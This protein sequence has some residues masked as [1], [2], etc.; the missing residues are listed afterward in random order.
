MTKGGK[1]LKIMGCHQVQR[2]RFRHYG[3][4][5]E[6]WHRCCPWWQLYLVTDLN[7]G[8]QNERK[9]IYAGSARQIRVY[10]QFGCFKGA[11]VYTRMFMQGKVRIC[12]KIYLWTRVVSPWDLNLWFWTMVSRQKGWS[13][14]IGPVVLCYYGFGL[15]YWERPKTIKGGKRSFGKISLESIEYLMCARSETFCDWGYVQIW[16]WMKDEPKCIRSIDGS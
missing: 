5:L 9:V 4:G 1:T 11:Y 6:L 7:S 14:S 3:T 15:W 13:H 10:T 2:G 16:I 8:F 12:W